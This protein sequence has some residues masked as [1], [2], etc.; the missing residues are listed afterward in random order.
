MDMERFIH[1]HNIEHFVAKLKEAKDE[2]TRRTIKKLLEE[3]IARDP[4]PPNK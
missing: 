1:E 3:E 4:A 2:T